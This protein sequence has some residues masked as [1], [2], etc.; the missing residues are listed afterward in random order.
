MI[1]CRTGNLSGGNK[2]KL[3]VA[4]C[5]IGAPPVI[6]LDEPSAGMDPDARRKMW[7]IITNVA[8]KKKQS[9]VIL[10]THSMDEAQALCSQAVIMTNGIYRVCGTIGRIKE[11]YGRGFD[12]SCELRSP[13]F[14]ELRP[15]FTYF[16]SEPHLS[17]IHI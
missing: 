1:H 16:N 3:V 13:E 10:T 7:A 15:M 8:L 6:F 11:L 5:L 2:R 14:E 4:M 9:T 12:V 17:L